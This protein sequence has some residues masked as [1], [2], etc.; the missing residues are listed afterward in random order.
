[1]VCGY[2]SLRGALGGKRFGRLELKEASQLRSA[3]CSSRAPRFSPDGKFFA[4]FYQDE[5]PNSPERLLILPFEG[6]SPVKTFDLA[7]SSRGVPDWTPDG[8]AITFYDSRTGTVNLWSQPLDGGPVKQLTE[9]KPD[10]LWARGTSRDG[11]FIA[12]ARGTVTSDVILI[13]DFQ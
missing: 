1:M 9:F 3:T 4:C 10:E 12:F 13:S 11:K 8:K 5:K 2:F 6:G 7:P